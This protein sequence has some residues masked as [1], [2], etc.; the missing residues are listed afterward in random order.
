M[1]YFHVVDSCQLLKSNSVGSNSKITKYK[2]EIREL[3]QGHKSLTEGIA[4]NVNHRMPE[5]NIFYPKS[6]V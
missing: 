2:I 6:Q 4:L 1:T 5:V 3:F